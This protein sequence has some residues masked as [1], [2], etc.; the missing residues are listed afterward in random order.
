MS[1]IPIPNQPVKMLGANETSH[2]DLSKHCNCL[3]Q[4]FY[5]KV[6]CGDTSSVQVTLGEA[7]GLELL[8]DGEFDSPIVSGTTDGTNSSNIVDSGADFV[9]DGVRNDMIA[10]NDT[11]NTYSYVNSGVL[12]GVT[13][14]ELGITVL[15]GGFVSGEDYKVWRWRRKTGAGF[16]AAWTATQY[17]RIDDGLLKKV[18]ETNDVAV[19]DEFDLEPEVYYKVQFT[20]QNLSKT[21]IAAGVKI[22]IGGTEAI[23]VGADGDYTFYYYAETP[24]SNEVVIQG[25]DA[26]WEMTNISIKKMTKLTI[27]ARNEATGELDFIDEDAEDIEYNPIEVDED[28]YSVENDPVAKASFDWSNLEEG[29][30]CPTGCY[31]LC[32]L[33]LPT[34]NI[35]TNGEFNGDDGWTKVVV[36]TDPWTI[37]DG[38]LTVDGSGDT[39]ANL[40]RLF[41]TLQDD[42]STSKKYKM[43]FTV[44]NWVGGGL[45]VFLVNNNTTI[46]VFDGSSNADGEQ[47]I[48]IDM[49]VEAFNE[50]TVYLQATGTDWVNGA[51]DFTL[52]NIRIYQAAET[53]SIL[54]CSEPFLLSSEHPCTQLLTWTNE[55]DAF[56]MKYGTFSI[57]HSL[58]IDSKQWQPIYE[59][60]DKSIDTDS[61]GT[62]ESIYSRTRKKHKLTLVEIPEY[63]HDAIAIGLEHDQF[64]IDGDR[65]V[66][67]EEEYTPVWRKS[68]LLAPV[69]IEVIESGQLLEKRRC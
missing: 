24:T 14:T 9:D 10:T 55:N 41:N 50:T 39:S 38:D 26:E 63:L 64:F 19:F 21:D 22:F 33:D 52:D 7:T 31:Q 17:I 46:Q 44:S 43:V 11:D 29:Y 32:L 8:S 28:G 53:V 13:A 35:I 66:S 3:G 61:I 37:D 57:V 40:H 58:R 47:E 42:L 5:Q 69:D 48:E 67:E 65:Y 23:F 49:T 56:G 27:A 45:F 51:S 18:G 36:V 15:T 1:V 60:I 25:V 16:G 4:K 54:N 59:K 12:P 34:N 2:N 20:I 62:I 30:A 68:S 6:E